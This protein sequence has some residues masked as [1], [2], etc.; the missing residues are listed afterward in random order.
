MTR[1]LIGLTADVVAGETQL[2]RPY[3][4]M[5]VKAGGLPVVLPPRAGV[6]AA[7]LDRLD[8]VIIT[9]GPDIDVSRFGIPLHPAAECMAPERQEAE[10]ALLDALVARPDVPVLGIC[11]G[12]QLMGVHRGSPLIQHL[13]DV[14]PDAARHRGGA[15]H[16]I[17]AVAGSGLTSGPVRSYHHQALAEAKGFEVVARS[18][19]GVIEAIRDPARRFCLGVQ[20]HPER[21]EHA[22]TGFAVL[23]LLVEAA[24]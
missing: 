15:E 13:A 6:R 7:M 20:W 12:M 23:R 9:G 19:D 3:L 17:E 2:T 22:D 4:D 8:G 14:L 10:F 16:A 11:L 21:T 24:R 1:P 5:V 18:D